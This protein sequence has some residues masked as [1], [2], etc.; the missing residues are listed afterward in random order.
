[1]KPEDRGRL[2]DMLAAAKDANR[3]A[4]DRNSS[5]LSEDRMLFLAL[6][7]AVEIIGEAASRVT[8]EARQQHPEIAWKGIIGM[9]NI[10]VHAYGSIDSDELWETIQADLPSLIDALERILSK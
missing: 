2:E 4:A 8:E 5:D 6:V 3:F 7:K 9:R 10:L 1:M